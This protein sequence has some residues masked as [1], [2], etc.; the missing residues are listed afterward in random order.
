ME[1]AKIKYI[2]DPL[3]LVQASRMCFTVSKKKPTLSTI[4]KQQPKQKVDP[5]LNIWEVPN[6]NDEYC[7]TGLV[8]A[9]KNLSQGL[10]FGERRYILPDF[11]PENYLQLCINNLSDKKT[12]KSQKIVLNTT[13][14]MQGEENI[15]TETQEDEDNYEP[16]LNVGNSDINSFESPL[17]GISGASANPFV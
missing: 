6:T 8:S 12:N 16:L 5:E 13:T 9:R 1:T 7:I 14:Q 15:E 17:D 3:G 10:M 2:T 11:L 4:Q